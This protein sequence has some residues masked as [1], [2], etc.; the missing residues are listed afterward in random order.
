M[1]PKR[2]DNVWSWL[3]GTERPRAEKSL[4]CSV[5]VPFQFSFFKVS[6]FYWIHPN[7]C[8]VKH[9]PVSREGRHHGAGIIYVFSWNGGEK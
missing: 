1:F 7:A 6:F 4:L 5:F 3:T 2:L 8:L 9:S